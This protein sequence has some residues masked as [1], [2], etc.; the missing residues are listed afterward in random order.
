MLFL[1]LYSF[2]YIP[3]KCLLFVL[4]IMLLVLPHIHSCSLSLVGLFF[5]YDLYML[6]CPK[7]LG[8]VFFSIYT[9][10]IRINQVIALNIISIFP[11]LITSQS[12]GPFHPT[13]YVTSH[14]DLCWHL[15]LLAPGAP[16][17][18]YL[19]VFSMS[20]N[21]LNIQCMLNTK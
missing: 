8:S 6:V 11:A 19:S 21:G 10:S 20:S 3:L 2:C 17:H 12:L 5:S 16:L 18:F 7:V 1:Q 15:K 4:F 14:P 9:L 13:A